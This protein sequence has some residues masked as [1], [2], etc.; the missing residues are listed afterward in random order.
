M[1]K[2]QSALEGDAWTKNINGF[3]FLTSFFLAGRQVNI[4][5]TEGKE[6]HIF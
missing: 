4:T 1:T 5:E 2:N 3:T 6:K